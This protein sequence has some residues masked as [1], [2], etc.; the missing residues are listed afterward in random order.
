MHRRDGFRRFSYL[1]KGNFKATRGTYRESSNKL[2]STG[3]I[4]IRGNLKSLG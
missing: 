1:K 3:K 4:E 2:E